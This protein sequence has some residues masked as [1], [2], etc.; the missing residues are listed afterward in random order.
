MFYFL[1]YVHYFIEQTGT[2]I[3]LVYLLI[4]IKIFSS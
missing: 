4:K 1:L 3:H 2:S